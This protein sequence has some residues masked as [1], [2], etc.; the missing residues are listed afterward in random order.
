[1]SERTNINCYVCGYE[2]VVGS[3]TSKFGEGNVTKWYCKACLRS[4]LE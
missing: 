3:I 1:M 2:Q 4:E